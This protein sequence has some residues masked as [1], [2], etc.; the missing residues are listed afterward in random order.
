VVD[1]QLLSVLVKLDELGP[2]VTRCFSR[3][4]PGASNMLATSDS[5]P[6]LVDN[7]TNSMG[8]TKCLQVGSDL[9]TMDLESWNSRS[10]RRV[11][12]ETR[13]TTGRPLCCL[14]CVD[15][16]VCAVTA[17]VSDSELLWLRAREGRPD[18]GACGAVDDVMALLDGERTW[19]VFSWPK[20]CQLS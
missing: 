8:R 9:F 1:R 6:V 7:L 16:W 18:S 12:V 5:S 11:W 10:S 20:K 2:K 3:L 15:A 13:H 17:L 4:G 14:S 19:N